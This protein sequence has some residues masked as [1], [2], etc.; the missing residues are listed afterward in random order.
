MQPAL[1]SST[2][3]SEQAGM[4]CGGTLT[5]G[6]D[7]GRIPDA[8]ARHGRGGDD[9]QRGSDPGRERRARRAAASTRRARQVGAV[10]RFRSPPSCVGI[11]QP[12]QRNISGFPVRGA[13]GRI[14]GGL[15]PTMVRNTC[16]V[17]VPPPPDLR[18]S[19]CPQASRFGSGRCAIRPAQIG[20]K[21]G[22]VTR[23]WQRPHCGVEWVAP[24]DEKSWRAIVIGGDPPDRSVDPPHS[25]IPLNRHGHFAVVRWLDRGEGVRTEPKFVRTLCGSVRSALSRS[26]AEGHHRKRRG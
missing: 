8:P 16:P 26:P 17:G 14:V 20:P 1:V 21:R 23:D 12:G 3:E 9:D 25:R 10:S 2:G 4:T 5:D 18:V 13:A 24:A 22:N 7:G 15:T 6:F 19:L 11:D